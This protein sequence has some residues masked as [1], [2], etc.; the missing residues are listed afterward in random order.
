MKKFLFVV[1]LLA[2]YQK[3]DDIQALLDPL[4]DYG[5]LHSEQ[6]ILYSTDWCGYCRQ[7]RQ[8]MKANNISYVEYDI[9]KSD[10]GHQQH[11]SLGGDGVPVLL[12]DKKVIHGYSPEKILEYSQ[13]I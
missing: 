7:A 6:V 2:V 1:A 3:W 9:E 13:G 5:A 10:V 11:K 8:L 12:I 4:P